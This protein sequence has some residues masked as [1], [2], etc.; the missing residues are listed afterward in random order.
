MAFAQSGVGLNL[1][2]RFMRLCRQLCE[3]KQTIDGQHAAILAVVLSPG[4]GEGTEKYN[5][6][7]CV[8]NFLTKQTFD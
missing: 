6:S 1:F 5:F 4:V 7:V 3:S 8:Q 2:L